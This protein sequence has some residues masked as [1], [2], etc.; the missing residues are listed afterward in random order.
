MPMFVSAFLHML[1]RHI[2]HAGLRAAG[3]AAGQ[4][5]HH[6]RSVRHPGP[7]ERQ[8]QLHD[9]ACMETC[10]AVLGGPDAGVIETV[11]TAATPLPCSS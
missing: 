2:H 7:R 11:L 1:T 3:A 5:G 4:A 10:C 8:H 9:G 6:R